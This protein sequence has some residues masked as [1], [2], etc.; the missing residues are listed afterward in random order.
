MK[1]LLSLLLLLALLPAGSIAAAPTPPPVDE[2]PAVVRIY[3]AGEAQ[4]AWLA[5]SGL[6]LLE[7]RGPD[8]L[9]ALLRPGQRQWLAAQGFRVETDEAQTASL[10][11]ALSPD[12]PPGFACYRDVPTVEAHLHTLAAQYPSLAELIDF[13]DSW[14]KATLGGEA[15]HDLWALRITNRDVAPPAGRSSKPRF[16]LMAAIHARELATPEV[17]LLFADW[18]LENY[19]QDPDVTWVV[20]HHEVW[21]APVTNPDGRQ[22]AEQN[23][24]WRKN[25]DNDDGCTSDYDTTYPFYDFEYY[26]VDLNRNHSF[27]WGGVG[28]STNACAETYRGPSAASEPEVQALEALMRSLFPDQRGPGLSDP[29]PLSTTGIMITLHSYGEL[30]LWPWGNMETPAPNAAGL[31]AIGRKFASF[32][33]YVACQSGAAG[34]LYPVSGS[35]DDWAYG[36]LGIPAFTFE[37]GTTFFQP[38]PQFPAIWT[39]NRPA[40]F[41]AAKIADMPYVRGQ[42]PE[43]LSPVLSPQPVG[44]GQP[45]V[46]TATVTDNATGG[47][48]ITLAEAYVGTP[49]WL[50]GTAVRLQPADGRFD[51]PREGVVGELDTTDLAPGRYLV[52]VRGRDAAGNWGPPTATWLE[53]AQPD[54]AVSAQPN[55]LALCPAAEA[56]IAVRVTSVWGQYDAGVSLS[57]Q[58]VPPAA[59]AA[60]TP[61]WVI[62]P[63]SASLHLALSAE[64]PPNTYDLAVVGTG[65]AGVQ[66]SAPV[67]L[68]VLPA[69]PAPPALLYPTDGALVRPGPVTLRW[70]EAGGDVAYDLQVATDADFAELVVSEAGLAAPQHIAESLRPGQ[71]Y[72]WR[73]RT[74]NECGQG[75]WS[76]PMQ[77]SVDWWRSILPLVEAIRQP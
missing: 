4:V 60:I 54:F 29:A 30:V 57:V 40:L 33:G 21:I 13:G 5:N 25:T 34:C 66:R 59:S 7:A 12:G 47:Q 22:R 68:S 73:V 51:S 50:G 42:G 53:V 77:F 36:E 67:A 28:T 63:A 69:S 17:A 41:Y 72:F 20:D 18:L 15:G 14:E 26:G 38:C 3:V 71:N 46:L 16:F 37:V 76:L 56:D 61:T 49:P 74:V 75:P 1:P 43:T 58:G 70:A 32:N 44:P 52:W 64:T 11:L 10:R 65:S 9:L 23:K 48:A 2:E 45:L 24:L 39:A 55:S 27:M 35:T 6:D 62:P 19:G 8:Y 31:Q